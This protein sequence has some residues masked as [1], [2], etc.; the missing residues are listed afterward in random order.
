MARNSLHSKELCWLC[1]VI[2]I[3]RVDWAS[4]ICNA[5]CWSSSLQKCQDVFILVR[6]QRAEK[7]CCLWV[8]QKTYDCSLVVF[9]T[10]S[11]PCDT[12]WSQHGGR[13]PRDIHA[14]IDIWLCGRPWSLTRSDECPC[15]GRGH[16]KNRLQTNQTCSLEVN[17]WRTGKLQ[18]KKKKKRTQGEQREVT[19]KEFASDFMGAVSN[20]TVFRKF[21]NFFNIPFRRPQS[22]P[23]KSG[24]HSH[25]PVVLSQTVL[26]R[27][28]AATHQQRL[29]GPEPWRKLPT[30]EQSGKRKE[31]VTKA[32]LSCV[33]ISQVL[34]DC[35]I[36]H[37]DGQIKPRRLHWTEPVCLVVSQ[38]G[39]TMTI[40]LLVL[41]HSLTFGTS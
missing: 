5:L 27:V 26:G 12:Q 31:F 1:P 17:L 14:C 2:V 22:R 18:W 8:L 13:C 35:R 23:S 39:T 28:L 21:C 24:I 34:I 40:K 36:W 38:N 30:Y 29:H 3:F 20:S 37:N 4:L 6:T 9:R 25:W 15:H 11:S 33:S 16:R 32:T 19:S 41:V 10:R 7:N